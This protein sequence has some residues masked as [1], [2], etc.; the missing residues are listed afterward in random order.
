MPDYLMSTGRIK[1]DSKPTKFVL[2]YLKIH[3]NFQT[4]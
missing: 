2:K 3:K 4:I 1:T